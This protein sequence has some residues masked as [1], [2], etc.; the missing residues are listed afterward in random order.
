MCVSREQAAGFLSPVGWLTTC[1]KVC[2]G[3]FVARHTFFILWIKCP[4]PNHY[5]FAYMYWL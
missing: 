4:W 2:M 5:Q 1:K 3:S